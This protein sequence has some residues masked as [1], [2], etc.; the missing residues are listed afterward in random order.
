MAN[1]SQNCSDARTKPSLFKKNQA[2]ILPKTLP[3]VKTHSTKYEK[4][5]PYKFCIHDCN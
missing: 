1:G 2:R 3:E 4:L 5:G